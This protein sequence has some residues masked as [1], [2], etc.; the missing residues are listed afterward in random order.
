MRL[1][2]GNQKINSSGKT[3]IPA[4]KKGSKA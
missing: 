1:F 4:E 3:E 2:A